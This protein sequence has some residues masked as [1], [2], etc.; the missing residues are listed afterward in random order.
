MR[1]PRALIP[2]RMA[3]ISIALKMFFVAQPGFWYLGMVIP[4]AAQDS[5]RDP[6]RARAGSYVFR[7]DDRGTKARV[8]AR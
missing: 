6:R 8:S 4:P 5:R 1:E 7:T 3:A 2:S